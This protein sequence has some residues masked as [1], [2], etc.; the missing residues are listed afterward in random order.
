[1]SEEIIDAGIVE[2]PAVEA[3]IVEEPVV[4]EAVEPV[5]E[6]VVE[7][8]QPVIPAQPEQPVVVEPVAQPVAGIAVSGNDVDEVYLAKCVY[9]NKF[10]RKS[11]TI[12]HLQRR[13]D[14]L[15]YPDAGS[16]KDGY[17]GDLTQLAIEKFQEANGLPVGKIDA[18]TF[19]KI[20][21]GDPHVRVNL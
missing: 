11:L 6:A 13:L 12:H 15:G 3:V 18:A 8:P 1:M 19:E 7:E 17:L 2:E 10:E 9:K 14:E 5:I 4:V 20:F 21:Q 16:D